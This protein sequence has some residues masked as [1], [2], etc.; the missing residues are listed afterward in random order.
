MMV[1]PFFF[2]REAY[3]M[4]WLLFPAAFLT[5][6]W[7]STTRIRA[8]A[9]GLVVLALP[10][11]LYVQATAAMPRVSRAGKMLARY[12]AQ[13]T[14]PED[15]VLTDLKSQAFPY[16]HWDTYSLDKLAD[17]LAFYEVTSL[18]QLDTFGETFRGQVARTLYLHHSDGQIEEGLA[19]KLREQGKLLDRAVLPIP[20]EEETGDPPLL[21]PI[22]RWRQYIGAGTSGDGAGNNTNR[23]VTLELYRLE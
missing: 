7:L 4:P 2:D 6:S 16:K 9:W 3:L 5:A 10:G 11:L 23:T 12:V 15:L 19:Q 14:N 17:R 1:S 13:H 18:K 22:Y 21:R 20:T 8:A